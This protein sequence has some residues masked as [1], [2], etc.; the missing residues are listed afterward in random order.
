VTTPGYAGTVGVTPTM[1]PEQLRG[2]VLACGPY[3]LALLAEGSATDTGR[4]LVKAVLWAYAGRRRYL[5]DPVFATMSVSE[6]V[7]PAFPPALVTVGNADPLRPHSELLVERLRANGV[8][9]ETL[10]FPTD[11]EPPLGHE[12]QFDLDS[13]AGRLFLE[14][15]LSFLRRRLAERPS[16]PGDE[17]QVDRRSTG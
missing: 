4:R 2:L 3:D 6:Q 16:P 5:D 7:T 10:F 8:K 9:T 11:H 15:L 14:R 12:Y 1:T 13:D 17:F